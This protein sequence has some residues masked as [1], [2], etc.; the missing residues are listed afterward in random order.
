MYRHELSPAAEAQLVR[1]PY[2]SIDDFVEALVQA[3]ADPWNFQRREDEPLDRH[4]AHRWVKFADG[5]GTL[6]FLIRDGEGLIWV[7]SVEWDG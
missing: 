3:C 2:E 4:H 7:T 5:R 1:L 6:S